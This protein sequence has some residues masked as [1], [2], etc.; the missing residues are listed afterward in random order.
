VARLQLVEGVGAAL[1]TEDDHQH[2]ADDHADHQR[3]DDPP[4]VLGRVVVI[5]PVAVEVVAVVVV[6]HVLVGLARRFD[7]SGRLTDDVARALV[8]Q[9]LENLEDL[10]RRLGPDVAQAT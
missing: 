2:D 9:L 3:T 5:V 6:G 10:T 7:D 4:G 1:E 8:R